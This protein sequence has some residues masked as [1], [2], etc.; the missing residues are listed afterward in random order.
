MNQRGIDA[1]HSND[2]DKQYFHGAGQSWYIWYTWVTLSSEQPHGTE[3]WEDTSLTLNCTTNYWFRG[4]KNEIK[5][6]NKFSILLCVLVWQKN[7]CHSLITS[8]VFC[9]CV[10][11]EKR[12][13]VWFYR[14]CFNFQKFCTGLLNVSLVR[15]YTK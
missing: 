12:A 3:N 9:R 10:Q 13:T 4:K 2:C 11:K 6:Q 5:K 1:P 15:D 7:P 14:L 8:C